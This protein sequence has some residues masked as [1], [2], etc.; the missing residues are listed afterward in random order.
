MRGMGHRDDRLP[1]FEVQPSLF[2]FEFELRDVALFEHL[3]EPFELFQVDAHAVDSVV[4]WVGLGNLR[5]LVV[6]IQPFANVGVT[7]RALVGGRSPARSPREWGQRC[8]SRRSRRPRSASKYEFAP[9]PTTLP[10]HAGASFDSL[11]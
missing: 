8:A 7:D 5:E 9:N 2:V 4:R 11:R 3:E 1:S 10:T 6:A